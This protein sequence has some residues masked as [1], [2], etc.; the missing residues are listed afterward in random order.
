MTTSETSRQTVHVLVGAGALLLRWLTWWQAALAAGAAVLFNVFVLP[1]ISPG[2]FRPGD[3]DDPIRSGIVIY[4]LA[5]LALI[6]CFPDRPDIAAAAW[7]ILAAGDGVATIAGL[8]IPSRPLSWNRQKTAAGLT[9]F[10]VCGSLAGVLLAFWTNHNSSAASIWWM[11][12]APC[13]AAAVAGFIE[14]SPIRL[15]D[16]VSVPAAAALVL[17]SLSLVDGTTLRAALPELMDRLAPAVLLNF[18]AAAAGWRARTVTAAGAI[19]GWCI[20]VVIFVCAGWAG[21]AVLMTSFFA[22]AAATRLGFARKLRA[23]IAEDRGG[24]RSTGNAIANTSVA[25]WLA[26]LSAGML[27]GNLALVG[28]V[29]ALATAAGDT[30]ASEVGKAWGRTTWSV[31]TFARVRPGTTGAVSAEGTIAG[32]LG[33]A[34]IA[35]VAAAGGL[36]QPINVLDVA[37]AATIASLI[38]GALGATLEHPGIL[39]NHALN[40][41][42]SLI[43]AALAVLAAGWRV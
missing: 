28:M 21:W 39:D 40:F 17:W 41:V 6:L 8:R 15:N 37:L 9:G 24:R 29:A 19:T 33:A 27:H 2:V 16:N 12:I 10:V 14:T 42:N 18:A 20:G 23:G 4:P 26:M 30:I 7:A 1:R 31:T 38:E 11:L 36:I 25:A 5:V 3:L 32:A 43:G 22:A 34:L 35:G 13:A